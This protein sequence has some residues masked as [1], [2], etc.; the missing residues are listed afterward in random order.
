MNRI[1]ASICV[2]GACVAVSA[3]PVDRKGPIIHLGV[4]LFAIVMTFVFW[5]KPS[6][7][8]E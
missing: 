1:S 4:A 7:S 6:R 8:T 2:L 5:L 3:I